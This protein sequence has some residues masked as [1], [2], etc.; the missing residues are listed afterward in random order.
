MSNRFGENHHS[1]NVVFPYTYVVTA[2]IVAF[3]FGIYQLKISVVEV[4]LAVL[5]TVRGMA[6]HGRVAKKGS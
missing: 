4:L 5:V 6:Y 3:S 1:R 2:E